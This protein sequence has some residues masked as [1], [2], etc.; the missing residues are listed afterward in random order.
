M[1]Q[2]RWT[3]HCAS[4]GES[5]VDGSGDHVTREAV[6]CARQLAGNRRQPFVRVPIPD[7]DVICNV[8]PRPRT[9]IPAR[10]R[11]LIKL[12]VT[13]FGADQEF[14]WRAECPHPQGDRDLDFRDL[15]FQNSR[16]QS[17]HRAGDGY[18][19]PFGLDTARAPWGRAHAKPITL[20]VRRSS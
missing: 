17:P 10:L 9:R 7:T 8:R 5:M 4:G 1:W 15:T 20:R 14:D 19:P 11:M 12:G 2:D 3:D 13:N 16:L 18:T 6:H